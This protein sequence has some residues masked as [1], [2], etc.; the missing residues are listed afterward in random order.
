MKLTAIP[1]SPVYLELYLVSEKE[2]VPVN[3]NLQKEY[4][5]FFDYG[6]IPYISNMSFAEGTGF[7]PREF[8]GLFMEIAHPDALKVMWNGCVLTKFTGKVSSAQ[9]SEDM[10]FRLKDA[11]PF[12][13]ELYSSVGAYNKA[14]DTLLVILLFGSILLTIYYYLRKWL[15]TKVSIIK[16]F[17]ILVVF[18]VIGFNYS[19]AKVGEKTEVYSVKRYW[20]QNFQVSLADL[21]CD[22]TINP[23][24]GPEFAEILQKNGIPNPITGEPIIIEQSPGNMIVEI[25]EDNIVMKIC[26]ENG[27]LYTLFD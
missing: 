1:G 25:T 14:Y 6:E 17:V 15:G 23:S 9:M 3:Y 2:A 21:F 7:I 4:C 20:V 12:Q 16:L 8:F 26:L 27:S 22:P 18:G 13:S 5:N 11:T 10:F 24:N 19:Y